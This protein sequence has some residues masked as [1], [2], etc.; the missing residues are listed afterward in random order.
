MDDNPDV[1]H[2]LRLLLELSGDMKVVGQADNG[3]EAVCLAGKLLPDA[4][5]LDLEM[6]G[7]DGYEATRQIKSQGAGPRVIILSIHA[8]PVDRAQARA[9]GADEFIVK[10]SSFESLR[11]AILGIGQSSEPEE[12]PG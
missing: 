12:S 6:P 7:M 2:D 3:L 10:G 11:N 8:S 1:L 4:I 9:S 5:V